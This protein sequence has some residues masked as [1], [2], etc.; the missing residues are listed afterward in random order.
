MNGRRRRESRTHGQSMVE[1]ALIAPVLFLLVFGFVDVG[2]AYYQYVTLTSA[3][4]E[5]ARFEAVNWSQKTGTTPNGT[6][7]KAD[8][9]PSTSLQGV[10]QSVARSA[11]MTVVNDATHITVT[12]YDSAGNACAHW[13]WVNN[14]V[15][16]DGSC[17]ND[18][19]RGGDLVDVKAVYDFK[20]WVPIVSQVVGSVITLQSDAQVRIE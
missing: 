5:A 19:P 16:L 13:D 15:Q 10:L 9:A 18:H 4:R 17:N 11:G 2:R 14:K 8:P 12:Y 6:L 7:S 20:L 3:V 1:F